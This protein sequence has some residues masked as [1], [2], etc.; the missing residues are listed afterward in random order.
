MD[1]SF[2]LAMVD[3]L[4]AVIVVFLTHLLTR[5]PDSSPS[6]NGSPRLLKWSLWALVM[7]SVSMSLFALH[8]S[9]K[10]ERIESVEFALHSAAQ[11]NFDKSTNT[12]KV[13][14][15]GIE[16]YDISDKFS[17]E[18][19]NPRQA[20]A[21]ITHSHPPGEASFISSIS[22]VVRGGNIHLNATPKSGEGYSYVNVVVFC[23]LE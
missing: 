3:L 21:A 1:K 22:A 15:G 9:Q 19:K 23:G 13:S 14:A 20:F 4:Q 5:K 18:C 6:T 16:N 7:G 12:V 10:E 17:S 2:F 11:S 8:N